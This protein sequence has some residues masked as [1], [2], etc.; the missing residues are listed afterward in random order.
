MANT[1]LTPF[2]SINSNPASIALTQGYQAGT[3]TGKY[4][5]YLKLFSGEMFKA[6]ESAC[7]AKGTVQSRQL[8]NG[9]SMQFVFTG[10]MTAD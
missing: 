8:S 5:L 2:G 4:A 10:R 6:Y 3:D 7:I 1:T 9:K